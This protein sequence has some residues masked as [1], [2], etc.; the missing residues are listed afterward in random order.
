MTD[1]SPVVIG[2]DP[3]QKPAF[4][5]CSMGRIIH[6]I[7]GDRP[8]V[9]RSAVKWC[10]ERRERIVRIGVERQYNGANPRSSLSVAFDAGRFV[11]AMECAGFG[12]LCGTPQLWQPMPSEWRA[13]FGLN[14]GKNR[15]PIAQQTRIYAE[16]R[17]SREN[18]VVFGK[19]TLTDDEAVACCLAW[20]LWETW[21]RNNARRDHIAADAGRK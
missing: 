16:H 3:G 19:V 10:R 12:D 13:L 8:T 2:F 17:A 9:Q 14:A 11:G 21:S 15:Q 18:A 7:S 1:T 5:A 4:A 6:V 20:A